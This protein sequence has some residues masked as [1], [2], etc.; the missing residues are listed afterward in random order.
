MKRFIKIA[1]NEI[2]IHIFIVNGVLEFLFQ[3]HLRMIDELKKIFTSPLP[4]LRIQFTDNNAIY[5]NLM[6]KIKYIPFFQ[7][8][9]IAH[10]DQIFI[11][12]HEATGKNIA[13]RY[14]FSWN[15]QKMYV[16]CNYNLLLLICI[17]YSK[18]LHIIR[19]IDLLS[20]IKLRYGN[21]RILYLLY[22]II[23]HSDVTVYQ[24]KGIAPVW[25]LTSGSHSS[26]RSNY[27][28]INI[29]QRV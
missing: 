5:I 24:I 13:K 6:R 20:I 12:Q 2:R 16:F 28:Q 4:I 14:R 18:Q 15:F 11:E 26:L 22:L 17:Y 1:N 7:W 8:L 3:T 10:Y 23:S 29:T 19:E 25:Q 27:C 9:G 21:E